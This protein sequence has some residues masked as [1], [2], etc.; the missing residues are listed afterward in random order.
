MES[1]ENQ[2]ADA[3]N[4]LKNDISNTNII[5]LLKRT[6]TDTENHGYFIKIFN[7]LK[8][9]YSNIYIINEDQADR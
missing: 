6:K 9:K 1:L 7:E 4:K 3:I 2:F 5:C 8:S